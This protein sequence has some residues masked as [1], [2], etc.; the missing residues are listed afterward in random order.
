MRDEMLPVQ[1]PLVADRAFQVRSLVVLLLHVHP[2]VPEVLERGRIGGL[3]FAHIAVDAFVERQHLQIRALF[4][5]DQRFGHVQLF[6]LV[7]LLLR[8][9]LSFATTAREG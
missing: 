8:F 5:L 6:V 7:A 1:I 3:F 4:P 2:Q 9:K